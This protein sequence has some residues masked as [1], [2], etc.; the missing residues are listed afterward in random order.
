M[1][2]R[3]KFLKKEVTQKALLPVPDK[4]KFWYELYTVKKVN[5]IKTEVLEGIR[6]DKLKYVKF[7]REL[8]IFRYDVDA[9]RSIQILIRDNLVKVL[10]EIGINDI[11][12]QAIDDIEEKYDL[13]E[14]KADDIRRKFMDD[15]AKL[16]DKKILMSMA[17]KTEFQFL[18]DE[19]EVLYFPFTNGLAKCTKEGISIEKHTDSNYLIWKEQIIEFDIKPLF[20]N[21]KEGEHINIDKFGI[22]GKFLF[23]VSGKS[24]ERYLS[25]LSIIGYNLHYFFDT[26]RRATVFT[27]SNLS[28]G[29]EGRSGKSLLGKMIMHMRNTC[30]VNGKNF[31]PTKEMRWQEVKEDTQIV[32]LNDLLKW[33]SLEHIYTDITEGMTI[34]RMYEKPFTHNAKLILATNQSIRTESGS[35]RDRILEFEFSNH[36][37]EGYSPLDEFGSW[38]YTE[39]DNEERNKFYNC[40]LYASHVYL[41]N[42]V[43]RPKNINLGKRKLIDHTHQDFVSWIENEG[44]ELLKPE[45]EIAVQDLYE[46]FKTKYP[47]NIDWVKFKPQK[48]G[49]Y[50]RSYAETVNLK[51]RGARED[52][53][54]RRSNNKDYYLLT[55][56]KS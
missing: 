28:Q 45:T 12:F 54:A 34:R 33:F 14:V 38:F 43:I 31:D 48:F 51:W 15:I 9:E 55:T 8:G 46:S 32:F 3:P 6:I 20:K 24:T 30:M 17:P 22:F 1:E 41:R 50:M 4:L 47:D 52:G 21:V 35:D 42:G 19:K 39:W 13:G 44:L 36:Y 56:K 25:L 29:A 27:D 5:G 18:K 16:L 37:S 49:K 53:Q 26:Q 11:V 7:L 10:T 23:N 2:L 40:M